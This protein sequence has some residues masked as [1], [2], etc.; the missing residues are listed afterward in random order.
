MILRRKSKFLFGKTYKLV[1]NTK[2]PFGIDRKFSKEKRL[3]RKAENSR[4]K[5]RNFM[6]LPTFHKV[7]NAI[8]KGTRTVAKLSKCI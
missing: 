3:A 6:I 8:T 4:K 5:G 2:I 1:R 7:R